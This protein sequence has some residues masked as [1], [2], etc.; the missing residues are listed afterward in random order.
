MNYNLNY[1]A[2][3]LFPVRWARFLGMSLPVPSNVDAVLERQYG[4]RFLT[5]CQGCYSVLL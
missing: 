2:S 3:E 5:S 1:S 4:P